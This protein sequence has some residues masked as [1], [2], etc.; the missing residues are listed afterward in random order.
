MAKI[1]DRGTHWELSIFPE[2]TEAVE[3]IDEPDKG[4][5]AMLGYD[6]S[7]DLHVVSNVTYSKDMYSIEDVMAKVESLRTCER[8]DTL[9]KERLVLE[10]INIPNKMPQVSDRSFQQPQGLEHLPPTMAHSQITAIPNQPQPVPSNAPLSAKVRPDIK[11]MFGNLVLD[12]YLTDAGKYFLGLM[13][14][15]RALTESAYPQDPRDLPNFMGNI[16]D[17]MSG[18]QDFMRSPEEAREFLSVMQ[19]QDGNPGAARKPNAKKNLASSSGNI[20]IY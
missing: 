15:D 19:V 2:I 1:Y 3:I 9:D 14:N 13:L 16:V 7:T 12:A 18:K 11:N 6:P 17:F 5:R 4:Y 8:C 20:I 10:S